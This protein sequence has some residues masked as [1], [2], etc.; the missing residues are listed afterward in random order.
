MILFPAIDLKDGACVRLVQGD[1]AQA[2]T[3]NRDPGRA[4]ARLRRSRLPVAA[5]GRPQRRLRRPLGQRRGGRRDP[6]GHRTCRCS[7]AA[8]SATCAA[9][10]GWLDK[11]IARVILGT[12]AV[13]D[14]RA[15]ARRRPRAFPGRIAVGIDARGGTVA[16]SG[17]AEATE[18][19]AIELARRFE[20]AGVAAI[21]YT[22][23]DRDGAAQGPQHRGD[24]EARPRRVDPGDRLGRPG[25]A[26]RHRAAARSPTA[27]SSKAPSPAARSMTAGSTRARR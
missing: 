22:D 13:N 4:G 26:R 11:G 3:F 18:M 2:T 12:V 19:D 1:M 27:R 24:A 17:W 9:I 25:L 16:V 21:I 10:E 20:D 8:A 6:G 7:S 23:I 5:R 14:P 15:G